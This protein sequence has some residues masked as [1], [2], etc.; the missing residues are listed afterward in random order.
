MSIGTSPISST[1]APLVGS[2]GDAAVG[3]ARMG[4]HRPD[5]RRGRSCGRRRRS[6]A[7]GSGATTRARRRSTSTPGR[8]S[9]SQRKVSSSAITI[10]GLRGALGRHVGERGPLV[11]RQRRDARAGELHHPVERLLRLRVVEQ[12]VEH[13]VLGR[14]PGRELAGQL[15]ADRLRHLH[16]GEALVHQVG[17]LGRPDAPG[18]RVVDAAHAGVA[19]GR[20]DEVAGIDQRLAR[21]LVADAGRDPVVGGEVAHAGVALELALQL[22]Q[23]LDLVRR[24]RA[25]CGTSSA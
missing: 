22:A 6:S 20:L 13:Q 18:E 12:D 3:I 21:H 4:D 10:A 17:V 8:H 7:P 2:R 16:L 23:G 9:A 1:Q 11:H 19:V 14:H 24:R 5:G 15:E 25:S